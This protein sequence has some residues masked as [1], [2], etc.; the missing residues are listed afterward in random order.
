MLQPLHECPQPGLPFRIVGGERHEHAD[1]SLGLLRVRS[2]RY[3]DSRRA[4]QRY[5]LPPPHGVFLRPSKT[6]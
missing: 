3:R 4:Y 6:P 2:E 5:E 1:A